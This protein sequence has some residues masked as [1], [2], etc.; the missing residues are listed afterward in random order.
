MNR[1]RIA[2][3]L[4][5]LALFV[6][7]LPA[8]DVATDRARALQEAAAAQEQTPESRRDAGWRETHAWTLYHL[9]RALLD[10]EAGGSSRAYYEDRALQTFEELAFFAGDGSPMALH[11]YVGIADVHA[12]R[13]A[14]EEAAH[15]YRAVAAALLGEAG[16]EPRRLEA[17]PEPAPGGASHRAEGFDDALGIGGGSGGAAVEPPAPD[18][19]RDPAADLRARLRAGDLHARE[20][21]WEA[22]AREFRAIV[23]QLSE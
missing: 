15:T 7:P 22:A 4:G 20:E 8:Q 1:T 6:A 16:T 13:G 12:R 11:A 21:D 17:V 14:W 9:G 19:P 5:A 3:A 2:P 10:V 23:R 18:E